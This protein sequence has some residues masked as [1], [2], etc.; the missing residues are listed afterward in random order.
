MSRPRAGTRAA[1]LRILLL[2]VSRARREDFQVSLSRYAV[3][4]LLFRLSTSRHR[5]AF[6][7]R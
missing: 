7:L 4:R 3:E 2:R 6:L 1:E 5:E